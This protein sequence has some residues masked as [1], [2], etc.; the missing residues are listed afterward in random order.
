MKQKQQKQ[1]EQIT[2][3]SKKRTKHSQYLSTE[4]IQRGLKKSKTAI[5]FAGVVAIIIALAGVLVTLWGGKQLNDQKRYVYDAGNEPEKKYGIVFGAGI[6]PDGVPYEESR[7][8]LDVAAAEYKSGKVQKLILSGDNR[9]LTYNEPTAMKYYMTS[10]H[11]IPSDDMQEDFA[12]R[13]TYETCERAKKVFQIDAALL[14]SARSHLPRAIYTCRHFGVESFGVASG[15]EADNYK[16]REPLAI[17]K[18]YINL[19]IRGEQTVL[20]DPIDF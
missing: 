13:S 8:R 10:V 16:R 5:S 1:R 17:L 18:M 11:K 6:N 20:G 15:V 7:A 4:A 19:Y 9:D 3:R 2:K 14:F 12:G